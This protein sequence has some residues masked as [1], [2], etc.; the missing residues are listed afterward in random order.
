MT[1]EQAGTGWTLIVPV[2]AT[3]RGKSRIALAPADRRRVA[4]ALALDTV[5]AAA[6]ARTVTTLVVIVENEPDGALLSQ[7]AGVR[8]RLTAATSLN[9]AITDGLDGVSGLVAVLPGDLPGVRGSDIDAA[10]ALAVAGWASESA[11][12]AV[13]ADRQ[14]V[15]S[16]LL[17]GVDPASLRPRY[18]PDSY[19][20]HLAAG[21]L[22]LEVPPDNWIRRDVDTAEDLAEI[23]TGRT[24]VLVAELSMSARACVEQAC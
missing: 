6:A 19:R 10:L 8:V 20:R 15:G 2:K 11:P 7:V 24:G 22:A 17:A 1:P 16:T 4:R 5:T 12:M 9:E 21:A 23:T 18:G 13:V 14:G 3:S